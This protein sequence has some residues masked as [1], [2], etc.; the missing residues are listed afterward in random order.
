[1]HL[2]FS[3]TSRA[4]NP[5]LGCGLPEAEMTTVYHQI[6]GHDA[7]TAVVDDFYVRVL[8]DAQLAPFFAG[9]NMSRLKGKQVEFFAAALGGPDAYS[10]LSMRDAHRGRAIGQVHFDL[11]AKHL[12]DAL[13]AAGVPEATA[14][15]IIET[16][17]P[18]SQDIVS[19]S[20]G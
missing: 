13:A 12:S 17:A 8:D 16:I 1:M 3:R 10:G 4:P 2:T 6:G 14:G 11:V 20:V 9:A 18:L 19:P 5:A 7:L 15:T